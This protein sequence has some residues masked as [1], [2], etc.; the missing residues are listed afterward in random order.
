MDTGLGELAPINE[1][2]AT[3]IIEGQERTGNIVPSVFQVGEVLHI[4][5]SRFQIQSIGRSKMKIKLLK[6]G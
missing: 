2:V 5:G 3:Q 6:Q 4:K 1:E